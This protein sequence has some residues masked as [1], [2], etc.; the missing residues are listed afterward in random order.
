VIGL[1]TARGIGRIAFS[2][3]RSLPT[4]EWG[5]GG[6]LSPRGSPFSTRPP[7]SILSRLSGA[8]RCTEFL[9]FYFEVDN[10]E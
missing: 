1:G 10:V 7:M 6:F 2:S 8:Q 9:F 5:P 4:S 3:L